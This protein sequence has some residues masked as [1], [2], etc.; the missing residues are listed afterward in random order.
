MDAT[1]TLYILVSGEGGVAAASFESDDFP[2]GGEVVVARGVPRL[3]AA[4]LLREGT[5]TPAYGHERDA[6]R[7][8]MPYL[9]RS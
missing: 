2:P 7:A 3:T 5:A 4:K 8:A 9:D 1:P 6:M